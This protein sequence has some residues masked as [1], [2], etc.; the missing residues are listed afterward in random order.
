MNS[1]HAPVLYQK[2]CLQRTMIYCTMFSLRYANDLNYVAKCYNPGEPQPGESSY[3]S[4]R[5]GLV[6]HNV[7]PYIIQ[8][9]IEGQRL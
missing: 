3:S 4:F 6:V 7:K 9:S 2:I 5:I 8:I 1:K